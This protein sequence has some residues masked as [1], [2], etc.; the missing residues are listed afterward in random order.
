MVQGR[1]DQRWRILQGNQAEGSEDQ[2]E[3][4]GHSRQEGF[5]GSEQ[6][7]DQADCGHL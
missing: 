7:A 4:S 6:E 2:V 3:A 1:Q 5:Q